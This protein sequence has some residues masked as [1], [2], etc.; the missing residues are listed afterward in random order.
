M[1]VAGGVRAVG[2][3]ALPSRMKIVGVEKVCGLTEACERSRAHVLGSEGRK[4]TA[5]V[6]QAAWCPGG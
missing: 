4:L 3:G 6:G 2:A 1:R 5:G